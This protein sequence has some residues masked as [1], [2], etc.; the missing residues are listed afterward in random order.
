MMQRGP[1]VDHFN[2]DTDGVVKAVFITYKKKDGQLVK[3]TTERKF[4][5]NDYHDSYYNEPLAQV[6]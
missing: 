2:Q 1:L 6:K 4:Y 5:G 3:E